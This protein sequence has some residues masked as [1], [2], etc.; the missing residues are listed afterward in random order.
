MAADLHQQLADLQAMSQQLLATAA[1]HA[2]PS[3]GAASAGPETPVAAHRPGSHRKGKGKG[4]GRRR[5]DAQAGPSALFG[6]PLGTSP[7]PVPGTGL[8]LPSAGS[9]LP[10]SLSFASS[11]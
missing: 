5:W 11:S 9:A 8:H 6:S 4:K 7:N 2:P 3:A 1:G 10:P